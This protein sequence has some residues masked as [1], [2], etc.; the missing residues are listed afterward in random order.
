MQTNPP[1][2]A[3]KPD[4]RFTLGSRKRWIICGLLFFATTINYVDR[5]ILS[6]V[7]PILDEKI[8][9]TNEQFGWVNSAF[10]ASYAVSLLGFGWLINRLGTK[11]GYAISIGSWSVAALAHALVHSLGGFFGVRIFLGLGEGG[12]FPA[13]IKAVATCFPKRERALA[14]SFFNSGSNVGAMLA[15]AIVPALAFSYGWQ[16]PFVLAGLAGFVWMLFLG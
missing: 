2:T 1:G 8:G 10:Q 6:L 5:Q 3:P 12:N 16:S 13:A 11:I 15:P 14:T 7:K 9:W 4:D